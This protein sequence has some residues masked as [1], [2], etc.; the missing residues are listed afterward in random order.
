MKK[1]LLTISFFYFSAIFLLKNEDLM[2]LNL[3]LLFLSVIFISIDFL[4]GLADQQSKKTEKI[5]IQ[6]A[7]KIKPKETLIKESPKKFYKKV[8][9]N[10]KKN[11]YSIDVPYDL[12]E[13]NIY[14]NPYLLKHTYKRKNDPLFIRIIEDNL[15]KKSSRKKI[16]SGY[17]EIMPFFLFELVNNK[18]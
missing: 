4:I 5:Y 3:F 10:Y 18:G 11:S 13:N 17:E 8:F 7:F 15:F 1:F 14:A 6:K 2:I 12:D 16:A 9:F